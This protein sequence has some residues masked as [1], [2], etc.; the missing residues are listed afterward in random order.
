MPFFLRVV[1]TRGNSTFYDGIEQVP[2]GSDA[3][4]L[5]D[6]SGAL[7]AA[8]AA[9]L[10]YDMTSQVPI[11]QHIRQQVK[12]VHL[13]QEEK[14]TT[15]SWTRVND[16]VNLS[17]MIMMFSYKLL[18]YELQPPPP[19]ATAI[20]PQKNAF[21]VLMKGGKR[22]AAEEESNLPSLNQCSDD[23]TEPTG[24]K[25]LYN[26]VITSLKDHGLKFKSTFTGG[27][28]VR[29]LTSS[30]YILLDA[31]VDTVAARDASIKRVLGSLGIGYVKEK[32]VWVRRSTYDD[33]ATSH[34][35]KEH[36]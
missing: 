28:V 9:K 5:L 27:E 31:S 21:A 2:D 19:R 30:V 4:Q 13:S 7:H 1:V 8:V 35:V 12:T 16:D 15:T 23:G 32:S 34:K 17:A 33:A 18:R 22:A 24:E 25:L 29:V 3:I 26:H 14:P 36:Y 20:Q 10:N 11:A 6:R